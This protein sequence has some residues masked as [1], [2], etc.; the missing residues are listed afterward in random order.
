MS[1]LAPVIK[2]DD[3]FW[4][5]LFELMAPGSFSLW[6]CS[7]KQDGRQG[8][9]RKLRAHT[10]NGN[11]SQRESRVRENKAKSGEAFNLKDDSPQLY[12]S[13]SKGVE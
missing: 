13:L 3:N 1:F 5:G 10:L 2:F 4:K 9:S 12:I 11:H 8:V 7:S 6:E